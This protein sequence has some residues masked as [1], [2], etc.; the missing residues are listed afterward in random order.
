MWRAGSIASVVASYHSFT[1]TIE[2]TLPWIEGVVAKVDEANP[3]WW[4]FFRVGSAFSN[5]V[6]LAGEE[7]KRD[8]SG[9]K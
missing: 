1:S 2:T 7:W 6:S 5:G 3:K 8:M 9:N 4:E